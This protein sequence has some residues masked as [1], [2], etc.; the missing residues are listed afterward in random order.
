MKST[1][2]PSAGAS[3]ACPHCKATILQSATSCPICRHVLRFTSFGFEPPRSRPTT[4]PLLVEGTLDHPGEG[5]PLEYSVL[6]EVRDETG[7]LL[8]RQTVGVGGLGSRERRIFTLRVEMS[9]AASN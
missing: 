7:K 9:S 6:M 1:R 3:R 4:C 5:A 2:A 8:S